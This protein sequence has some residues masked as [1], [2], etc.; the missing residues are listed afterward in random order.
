MKPTSG[1]GDDQAVDLAAA[2]VK[3]F[4]KQ[5]GSPLGLD[6]LRRRSPWASD[7]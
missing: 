4:D 3:L 1:V 6:S 2:Y 7:T 5:S